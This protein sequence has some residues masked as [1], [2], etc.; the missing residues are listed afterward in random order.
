M[1][2]VEL[3]AI[4]RQHA[5]KLSVF[6]FLLLGGSLFFSFFGDDTELT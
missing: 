3:R 6:I 2:R 4:P 5:P 1:L